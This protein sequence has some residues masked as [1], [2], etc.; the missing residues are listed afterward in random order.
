MCLTPCF[1]NKAHAG[2]AE[3]LDWHSEYRIAA[4][5]RRDRCSPR[6]MKSRFGDMLLNN[7]SKEHKSSR[8]EEVGSPRHAGGAYFA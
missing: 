1:N 7:N 3:A 4:P 2:A 5:C 8:P 6:S